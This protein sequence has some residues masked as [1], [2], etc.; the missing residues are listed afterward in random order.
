M[1][2]LIVL[3]NCEIAVSVLEEEIRGLKLDLLS[4]QK[5]HRGMGMDT[6]AS[7]NIL[8]KIS[9]ASQELNRI[10]TDY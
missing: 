8:S 4:E 7:Q 6:E 2:A 10:L 5:K 9:L 1:V 3:Q